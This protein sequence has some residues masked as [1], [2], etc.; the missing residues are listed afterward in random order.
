MDDLSRREPASGQP[1]LRSAEPDRVTPYPQGEIARGH[2]GT[3]GEA[4]PHAL[5][6]PSRKGQ[7]STPDAGSASGEVS[8]EQQEIVRATGKFLLEDLDTDTIRKLEKIRSFCVRGLNVATRAFWRAEGDSLDAFFREND[9]KNPK[10]NEWPRA[11]DIVSYDLIREAVP[12]LGGAIA[13]ALGRKAFQRW[14]QMRYKAL[15]LD[16]ESPPHYK[17]TQPIPIR[18]ADYSVRKIKEGVFEFGFSLSSVPAGEHRKS[19]EFAMVLRCRDAYQRRLLAAIASGEWKQG[20]AAIKQDRLRWRKWYVTIA[21]KR[22]VPIVKPTD[23][24]A[25]LNRGMSVFLAGYDWRGERFLYD[26]NDI[27]AFLKQYQAR[28]REYQRDK[29]MSS[30]GG[31]GRARTLQPILKLQDAAANYRATKTQK[32]ARE[33]VTKVVKHGATV[34]AR[35]DFTGIRDGLPENLVG[36]KRVW[37]AIQ[38]WPFYD[39]GTRIDSCA[40]EL[41]LR[42]VVVDPK[43]ITR[44]CPQCGHVDPANVNLRWRKIVCTAP[45]CGYKEHL[46]VAAARNVLARAKEVLAAEASAPP[47]EPTDKKPKRKKKRR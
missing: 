30:R 43:D 10:G 6:K 3:S 46:D 12:G 31:H 20:E 37:D 23:R 22:R 14:Y 24:I 26:A 36:G 8:A 7:S 33:W 45:G 34:I 17:K 13:S 42:V 15:V 40:E 5:A 25:A 18:A 28:R 44:T 9:G 21:Y 2:A 35:E 16:E 47:P 1:G 4:S 19:K 29:K 11:M 38:E 41:G 32:I 27:R 39:L